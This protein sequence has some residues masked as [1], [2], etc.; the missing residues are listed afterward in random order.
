[1]EFLEQHYGG[2]SNLHLGSYWK[3]IQKKRFILGWVRTVRPLRQSGSRHF[4]MP[5]A[6]PPVSHLEQGTPTRAAYS[7]VWFDAGLRR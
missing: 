3:K 6:G 7:M 4:Q 1:L 2:F 5:T